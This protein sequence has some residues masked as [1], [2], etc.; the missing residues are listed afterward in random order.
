M[1]RPPRLTAAQKAE[2]ATRVS[3]PVWIKEKDRSVRAPVNIS[4]NPLYGCIR[5]FVQDLDDAVGKLRFE[6]FQRTRPPPPLLNEDVPMEWRLD[7]ERDPSRSLCHRLK[8]RDLQKGM[9]LLPSDTPIAGPR[10]GVNLKTAGTAG[11]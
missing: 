11:S 10:K 6:A 7:F 9:G 5:I 8:F 3:H 1:G 4:A 2:A